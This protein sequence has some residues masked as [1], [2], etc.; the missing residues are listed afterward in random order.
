MIKAILFDF[1]GTVMDTADAIIRSWQHT[2]KVIDGLEKDPEHIRKSFG[3][4]MEVTMKREF[5][6]TPFDEAIQIYRNY[7]KEI[8][9]DAIKPFP[10]MKETIK[11]LY[12]RGIR[13]AIVTS[14]TK[15][16]LMDG[17]R[18]NGMMEYFPV[19]VT[20]DDTDEHKPSP[21]P[22]QIAMKQLGVEPSECILIGDSYY[23]FGCAHSAGVKAALVSW[24][25]NLGEEDMERLK[26][27]YFI[28]EAEDILD[29]C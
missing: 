22:A 25:D 29:L 9:A 16:S 13:M 1:D 4:V 11:T 24:S 14:R 17:L 20:C 6:N 23:D 19:S 21:A 12:E 5:P 18:V 3:E 7:Q 15:R 2:Y 28:R 27:E 10:G 8:F 26:I